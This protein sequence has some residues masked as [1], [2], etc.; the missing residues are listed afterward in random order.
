MA[1]QV[2]WSKARLEAFISEALLDETDAKIMR[3]HCTTNMSRQ[4]IAKAVKI[5][6]PTLDYHIRILKKKYDVAQKTCDLLE[7]RKRSAK[8]TFK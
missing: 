1:R 7:P 8:E 5:E 4:E 2:I 3:L 6:V